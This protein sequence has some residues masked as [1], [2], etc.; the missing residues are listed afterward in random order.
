MFHPPHPLP[1]GAPSSRR[2][3]KGAARP[4]PRQ[5]IRANLPLAPVPLAPEI[6]LH[7]AHPASGLWRLAR[8][9][10]QGFG[11]PYWAYP[12]AGGVALARYI[13]DRPATV[14]GRRV[15]DLG[16]GSGI[17]A[18]AAAMAGAIQVI[19]ADVDRYA[20]GALGLNAEANGVVVEALLDDLTAGLPPPVDL[21]GVG[22]LFY[23]RDLA[24]RV[25]AFLDRCLA[26]GI[27]VL[28]GDPHRPFLPRA[29]LRLLAEHAVSDFG[30]AKD[31][32]TGTSAVFSFGPNV[33]GDAPRYG[34]R[35]P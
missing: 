19:A 31:A 29:R 34:S 33:H 10:G 32:A 1:S 24:R 20:L 7:T 30:E 35:S 21:I 3:E 14:A 8:I 9:D 18:I 25:T 28:I 17:V 15:L 26:C 6:R 13:L 4:D 16:A 22:D 27:E 23:E 11:S 12:W 5:F 2:R